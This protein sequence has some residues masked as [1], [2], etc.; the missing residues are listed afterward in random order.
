MYLIIIYFIINYLFISWTKIMSERENMS[1][2]LINTLLK[3]Q[4]K[5]L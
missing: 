2:A 4:K 1:D 3:F 5:T